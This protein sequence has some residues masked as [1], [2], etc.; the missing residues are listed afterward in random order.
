MQ[1]VYV[2]WISPEDQ[3]KLDQKVKESRVELKRKEQDI[4]A[5]NERE[6]KKLKEE[7][8]ELRDSRSK[9][10]SHATS[11]SSSI[12]V[13]P[14]TPSPDPDG[15]ETAAELGVESSME[16]REQNEPKEQSVQA[17]TVISDDGR[18]SQ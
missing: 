5:L 15:E 17:D 9:L 10:R 1:F 7:I 6:I 4:F 16:E 3:A 13:Y 2:Q 14:A 12:T 8:D 18:N 11:V